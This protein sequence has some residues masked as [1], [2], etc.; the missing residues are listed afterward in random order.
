MGEVDGGD[1]MDDK[2]VLGAIMACR[3]LGDTQ[4]REDCVRTIL[5]FGGRVAKHMDDRL[6]ATFATAEQ[7]ALACMALIEGPSDAAPGHHGI[8]LHIDH[9]SRADGAPC[10]RGRSVADGL[11]QAAGPGSACL[12][13]AIHASIVG[14]LPATFSP[15]EDHVVPGRQSPVR[16]VRMTGIAGHDHGE[17][18]HDDQGPEVALASKT[19]LP[20]SRASTSNTMPA[21]N[22]DPEATLIRGEGD[23]DQTMVVLSSANLRAKEIDE[24]EKR[25]DRLIGADDPYPALAAMDEAILAIAGEASMA[26]AADRISDKRADLAKRMRV[27]GTA[28]IEA[29]GRRYILLPEDVISIG[30]RASGRAAPDIDLSF[31]LLSRASAGLRLVRGD[32]G[33]TLERGTATNSVIVDDRPVAPGESRDLD[34]LEQGMSIALG[35]VNEPPSKGDCRLLLNQVSG[36]EQVVACQLALDHLADSDP[37]VLEDRW[38][39][40]KAERMVTWLIFD[41]SLLVGGGEG[42]AVRV[43]GDESRA[44]GRIHYDADG[45]ELETFGT[46]IRI[47]GCCPVAKVPLRDGAIIGFGDQALTFRADGLE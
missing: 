44:G 18:A 3:E 27:V 38:P 31:R 37:R 5:R 22:L 1:R 16:F 39:N 14:K 10:E 42:C 45:Y 19:G 32:R 33:I 13:R 2:E 23:P 47:D 7:G 8:G 26:R 43:E 24:L 40:L 28:H 21:A 46:D 35:G 12:S 17:A 30:R 6:F 15:F 41:T 25:A 11:C 20:A 34:R 36:R 4:M 9:M 29:A